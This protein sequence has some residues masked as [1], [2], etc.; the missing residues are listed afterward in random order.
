MQ[1]GWSCPLVG[2]DSP[3]DVRLWGLTQT[4]CAN[5]PANPGWHN[6]RVVRS[7]PLFALAGVATHIG[8]RRPTLKGVKNRSAGGIRCN[9]TAAP[10]ERV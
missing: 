3:E 2:L 9:R 10:H 8:Y 5:T 7:L 1:K 6:R 4:R